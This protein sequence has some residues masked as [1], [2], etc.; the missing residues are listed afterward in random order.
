MIFGYYV[1]N[2]SF[3]FAVLYYPAESE[4]QNGLSDLAVF[5][6]LLSLVQ[7]LLLYLAGRI[8]CTSFSCLHALAPSSS[9]MPTRNLNS[10]HQFMLP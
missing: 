7:R 4:G 8:G 2:R 1:F 5:R 10:R 6:T 3:G 9:C